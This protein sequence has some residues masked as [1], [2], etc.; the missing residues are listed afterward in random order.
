VRPEPK[1]LPEGTKPWVRTLPS[2]KISVGVN[3]NAVGIQLIRGA[4]S[5]M[6]EEIAQTGNAK[7]DGFTQGSGEGR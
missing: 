7:L 3:P 1:D 5:A 4:K 6:K 2:G